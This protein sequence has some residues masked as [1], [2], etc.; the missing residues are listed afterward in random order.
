MKYTVLLLI[1]SLVILQITA[2]GQ[3]VKNE[4]E[5][6]KQLR[7][8]QNTKVVPN[9]LIQKGV[10]VHQIGNANEAAIL[11]RNSS[12][13]SNGAFIMQV[14]DFNRAISQ[15]QG[16]GNHTE[17]KQIG[18][19]NS[20]V[21]EVDGMYNTSKVHQQ[22]QSNSINQA[23]K[24]V[25]LEHTLIQLG[26]NNTINQVETGLNSK[27]YKVVQEGNGMNITIEQSNWALPPVTGKK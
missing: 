16:V 5:L 12:P 24:G 7:T 1:F 13:Q 19:N 26:N 14:G 20:Y 25:N 10:Q 22:G 15:Q 4:E 2:F 3:G 8:E 23:V 9:S 6:L 11:Q 17:A 18:V 27:S 21:G